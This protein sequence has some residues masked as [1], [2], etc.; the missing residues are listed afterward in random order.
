MMRMTP[1]KKIAVLLCGSGFK[2]GSEIRESVG[3]LWALS[4][5]D[6]QVDCFA[7]DAPQYDVVNCLTGEVSK[8]NRNQLIE[9]ARIARG[10]IQKLE[11]LNVKD[12]DALIVPGGFGAAKNLCDFALKGSSGTA[13]PLVEEKL[14]S[15]HATGNVIGAV[16]IA[17]AVLALSFRNKGFELTVG[18]PSEA[19]GE[20]EK[21]GHRHV[22]KAASD[23]C[24]DNK[25]KI[26]TTP[27]YMYDDAPLHE[28][29]EGIRKLVDAVIKL[30]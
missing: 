2:D 27:A 10:K 6:V 13:H 5:H 23:C 4:R 1:T 30:S 24:I 7:L 20:I 17:P 29:F 22:V 3:V 19:S 8:E 15:F 16:C 25:F 11:N 28:I 14:L 18:A 9:A 26:V 21:L 12:Y